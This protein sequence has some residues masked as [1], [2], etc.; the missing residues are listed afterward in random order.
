MIS[1]QFPIS[2]ITNNAKK[3][4]SSFTRTKIVLCKSQSQL[5][6]VQLST[7]ISFSISSLNLTSRG[8]DGIARI[9]GFG[10]S[11]FLFHQKKALTPKSRYNNNCLLLKNLVPIHTIEPWVRS[12]F[13][14]IFLCSQSLLWVLVQKLKKHTENIKSF[15]NRGEVQEKREF[16]GIKI[17]LNYQVI[18]PF[19]LHS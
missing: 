1:Q 12:D 15:R 7:L 6:S 4:L 2:T 3:M 5:I 13:S 10:I 19:S 11:I 16:F 9:T 8:S 14:A 18:C 17:K